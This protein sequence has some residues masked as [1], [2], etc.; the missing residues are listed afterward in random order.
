MSLDFL[1]L[2]AGLTVLIGGGEV[3]IRGAS[4]LARGLGVSPLAVGLTV[5]AFGTS[6]PELAVNVN[7]ALRDTGALSFGNVFGSNMANIGL[8][9]GLVAMIQPI[10]I[11]N[12]VI[13]RELPMMLLAT[14]AAIIMAFDVQLGGARD[15]YLRGDGIILLLF[16]VIFLYYTIGDLLRPRDL[17]RAHGDS[18]G[19]TLFELEL[20]DDPEDPWIARDLIL[21]AIGLTALIG[22]AHL[23]VV[24]AVDLARAFDVPEVV[25]GLTMISVG[26][27]LPELVAAVTAVRKGKSDMAV[28]TVVGSNI[29]NILLVAGVTCAI[30][31]MQIPPGGRI[32]LAACALLSLTFTLMASTHH[33]LIIRYE[34]A[35]LLAIY[36]AYMTWRMIVLAAPPV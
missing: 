25:I 14:A 12:I 34:G 2:I 4:S 1:I 26:T 24:S 33:R 3:V 35:T 11:H 32:D 21:V 29:F 27:S 9:V 30:R 23:T 20:E 36:L 6:A 5:V 22:G 7:A 15:A 19:D 10:P 16:F 17:T 31:P 28:G 18:G 8:I 13:R